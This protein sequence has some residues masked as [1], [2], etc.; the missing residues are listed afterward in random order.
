MKKLVLGIICCFGLVSNVAAQEE[1]Q[2]QE[3]R[4]LVSQICDEVFNIMNHINRYEEEPLFQATTMTQHAV[5]GQWYEGSS[6]MFVNW[7]TQTYS[8]ITLYPDGT[9]CVQAVG[10]DFTPYEG[11]RLHTQEEQKRY[12]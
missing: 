5:N 12:D 8:F 9:A 1:Q 7:D 10:T 3:K 11:R 2:P 6:M 4:F